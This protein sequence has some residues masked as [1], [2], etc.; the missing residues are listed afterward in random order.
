MREG[1]AEFLLIGGQALVVQ[2]LMLGEA[3][4]AA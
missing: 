4:D 3:L 1:V 2:V